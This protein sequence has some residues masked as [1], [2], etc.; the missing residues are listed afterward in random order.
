M[1]N[2]LRQGLSLEELWKVARGEVKYAD[3]MSKGKGKQQ[4]KKQP[5]K[6][7][8]K[9]EGPRVPDE[10]VSDQISIYIWICLHRLGPRPTWSLAN[11]LPSMRPELEIDQEGKRLC[12]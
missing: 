2:A 11:T 8:S 7:P 6:Q 10:L 5:K 3:F 9:R 1:R 4:G 12:L